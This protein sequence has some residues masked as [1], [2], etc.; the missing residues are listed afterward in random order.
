M[1]RL[2]NIKKSFG[3]LSAVDDISLHIRK[4]ELFSF[5]GRM[6]PEKPPPSK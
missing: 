6:A 4:G 2:E 5:L 3:A 1:I